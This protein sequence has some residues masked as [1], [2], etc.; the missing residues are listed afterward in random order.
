[1]CNSG[2]KRKVFFISETSN[3]AM[4]GPIGLL[5][6]AYPCLIPPCYSGRGVIWTTHLSI[7]DDKIEWRHLSAPSVIPYVVGREIALVLL[8]I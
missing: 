2:P 4:G 8:L 7:V 3:P 6:N 5:F 1:M